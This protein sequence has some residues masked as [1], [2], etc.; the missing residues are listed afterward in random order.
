MIQIVINTS[1]LKFFLELFGKIESF[2][3]KSIKDV[4]DNEALITFSSYRAEETEQII[5][6]LGYELSKLECDTQ[7][8]VSQQK[9]E[10]HIPQC[11]FCGSQNMQECTIK[12]PDDVKGYVCNNCSATVVFH[13]VKMVLVEKE[14]ALK[15]GKIV[16][17]TS[18]VLSKPRKQF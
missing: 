12:T 2:Y 5:F 11:S 13:K 1:K 10:E 4:G 6:N 7:I 15:I 18:R 17:P 8:K 16:S 3:L 9:K 14:A